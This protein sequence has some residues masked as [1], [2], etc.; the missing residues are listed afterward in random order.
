MRRTPPA[1]V[2]PVGG[3]V[4]REAA[5]AKLGADRSL[6]APR[7]STGLPWFRAADGRFAGATLTS[8]TEA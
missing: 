2:G 8:C 6:A 1:A 3:W 7:T 5:G 4:G